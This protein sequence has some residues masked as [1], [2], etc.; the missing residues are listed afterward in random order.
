M[1]I[2]I[3]F[4]CGVVVALGA[5]RAGALAA[6]GAVG[7]ALVGG[8]I[9]GFG[10]L[11][12]AALLLTFF[13]T[14]SALSRFSRRQKADL[15]EKF[16]KGSQ[17]DLGQ[18]LANGGAGAVFALLFALSQH[19]DGWWVAFAGAMAAVNADT[20]ATELGVLSA[21]LP[22]LITTGK[23][24]PRGAS[25]AVTLLGYG[26]VF[27]GA[28]LVALVG[29]IFGALQVAPYLA[30]FAAWGFLLCVILGGAAGSTF[31]S[32]LGASVQTIYICPACQKETERHPYHTCG[33]ATRLLRGWTWLNNDWVNFFCSLVGAGVALGLWV[34]FWR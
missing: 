25:G 7:A 2:L 21:S 31:D 3:G 17:R 9:F 19:W 30:P 14:S 32:L 11:A 15:S 4:I 29:A 10:G 33:S 26:A 20:W 22:R 16:S 8:V 5:W 18:V 12:W 13:I 28:G 6:S 34:L 27:A 23:T 24:A 1:Q